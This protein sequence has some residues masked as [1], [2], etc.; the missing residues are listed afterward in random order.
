MTFSERNELIELF[1]EFICIPSIS[2]E[3]NESEAAKW[4]MERFNAE[5]LEGRIIEKK[6]GRS[7]FVGIL[8]GRNHDNPLTFMSHI[9]VVAPG[10]G[11]THDPFAA[12]TEKGFIYG[13]GTL[14]TKQLTIMQMFAMF[15]LNRKGIVPERDVVLI[16]SADEEC[17]SSLG[18]K[19]L[20][21]EHPELFFGNDYVSEGGG[22]VIKAGGRIYRTCC[23]GEKGVIEIT[24]S[25][26][27]PNGSSEARNRYFAVIE[28]LAAFKASVSITKPS[29]VFKSVMTDSSWQD[30]TLSNLWEY[31]TKDNLVIKAFDSSA[32]DF[33]KGFKI[34]A[35]YKNLDELTEDQIRKT[36]GDLVCDDSL[37]IRVVIKSHPYSCSLESKLYRSLSDSTHKLDPT[38]TMLPMIALGNTDGRFIG[39]NTFGCSPILGNIPFSSVLKKVHQADE[40]ID[41]ESLVFGTDVLL[42]VIDSNRG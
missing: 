6:P 41:E 8:K 14:D 3:S 10:S 26:S 30:K 5:G 16:G 27:S 20:T 33:S 40:C 35:V 34:E 17:G 36:I 18:M 25:Y 23:C 13:R 22:F 19:F 37:D 9:D 15:L 2:G 7:N 21:E 38:A 4:L 1:K 39:K 24:I 12:E 32:I 11:W 42:N 31:S 28:K 29:E